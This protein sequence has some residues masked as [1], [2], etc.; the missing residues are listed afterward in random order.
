MPA[1][2]NPARPC[3]TAGG[4]CHEA[5]VA[6][7]RRGVCGVLLH[8]RLACVE[9]E[10]FLILFGR[11]WYGMVVWKSGMDCLIPEAPDRRLINHSELKIA[12]KS[13]S[14]LDVKSLKIAQNRLKSFK[15]AQFR[16]TSL[17]FAR[18]SSKVTKIAAKS[19][20]NLKSARNRLQ[21][22]EFGTKSRSSAGQQLII[23][24]VVWYWYGIPLLINLGGPFDYL[25]PAIL[26]N[27][28]AV[29]TGAV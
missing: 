15:I 16:S 20:Q 11:D 24:R 14:S 8:A 5:F 25:G 26:V 6:S 9:R 2:S 19:A 29:N 17:S 1:R 21:N 4:A 23:C 12:P 22:T 18:F 7:V 3:G 10:G 28:K 27:D 13:F